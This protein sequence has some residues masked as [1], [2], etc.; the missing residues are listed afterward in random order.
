MDL[1]SPSEFEM[2]PDILLKTN[3]HNRG[4][5]KKL[6]FQW[7]QY[8]IRHYMIL[9]AVFFII[10]ILL[11]QNSYKN[12]SQIQRNSEMISVLQYQIQCIETM[13]YQIKTELQ[14]TSKD[15][16][17]QGDEKT[18]EPPDTE[19]EKVVE[20]KATTTIQ[21]DVESTVS[22]FI[23]QKSLKPL[24]VYEEKKNAFNRSIPHFNA[25][26]ILLGASIDAYY[27]SG[28]VNLFKENQWDYVIL[29]RPE[30][31]PGKSWCTNNTL[32]IL[33]INLF[34]YIRPVAISYQ[35]LK[36]NG[37]VPNGAP[38]I[39]DVL[40]CLD[41]EDKG[42]PCEETTPLV[43]NCVYLSSGEQEQT[44]IVPHNPS[45]LPTKKIQ[46]QFRRNYGD[47]KMTCVSLVRVYGEG[48]IKKKKSLKAH[49][50]SC[51]SLIWYRKN[52][53]FVYNNL[54]P[55]NCSVLYNNDCCHECPDCCAE[56]EMEDRNIGTIIMFLML[57]GILFTICCL[58]CIICCRRKPPT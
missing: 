51:E 43:N 2:T 12:T 19:I 54:I 35:H 16:V 50:E 27:S 3:V 36:W 34:K 21:P 11:L 42:S 53:P 8:R 56:C 5:R 23:P 44:C 14:K 52:Y 15:K 32:P 55:K 7:L 57:C 4:R 38:R 31:Q 18:T 22:S 25:A 49:K 17:I 37:R 39:Y 46:I 13:V 26:N 45:L 20:E 10:L 47:S 1:E 30:P 41:Q 33:T 24:R 6:W 29:D 28:T 9:E 48:R 58:P 40:A